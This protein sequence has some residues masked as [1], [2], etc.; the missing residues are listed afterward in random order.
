MYYLLDTTRYSW[1]AAD[2][3]VA[4]FIS[5]AL[6]L[7]Q[8]AG[9]IQRCSFT[10]GGGGRA[11]LF[12]FGILISHARLALRQR[13]SGVV[14]GK[15]ERHDA[16]EG[17]AGRL[18]LQWK[19]GVRKQS[20]VERSVRERMWKRR[21]KGAMK[22]EKIC[23]ATLREKNHPET[24]IAHCADRVDQGAREMRVK[25]RTHSKLMR[26]LASD[27]EEASARIW[28]NAGKRRPH[29]DVGDVCTRTAR[30]AIANTA[31]HVWMGRSER[32]ARRESNDLKHA[33]S[34]RERDERRAAARQSLQWYPGSRGYAPCSIE[35]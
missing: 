7:F 16:G 14:V 15:T 13:G 21:M 35:V 12:F 2:C 9:P 3:G 32:V 30:S 20:R 4:S 28:A 26:E 34:I 27:A 31:S 29:F 25:I 22:L 17:A 5:G 11:W 6:V 8:L 24:E 10:G 23:A 1:R 18:Q 33:G 19:C